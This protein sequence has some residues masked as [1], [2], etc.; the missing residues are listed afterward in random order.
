MFNLVI[1]D[2]DGVLVDSERLAIKVDALVLR[3]LGLHLTE[4]EIVERFVGTSDEVFRRGIESMLNRPLPENWEAEVEPLYREAFR[5]ELVPVEGIREALDRI[6]QPICVAS[7]GSHDKMRFTLGMTGLYSY[8]EGRIFS[9]TEVVRGKPAPDLFLHAAKCMGVEPEACAV[10][11]D[12]AL[13][14]AA[15]RAAG[16]QVFAFSGSV[17]PAEKLEGP[18]TVVFGRL[19]ELPD[20]LHAASV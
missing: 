18:R 5:R 2:C 6:S 7:S 13:G 19:A 11:E 4:A 8:F 20:L 1:F 3:K 14:A 9:A 12:S 16:M 10:V 17:T 15:G